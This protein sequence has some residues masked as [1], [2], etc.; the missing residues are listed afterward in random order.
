MRLF[1]ALLILVGS[2]AGVIWAGQFGVG[3]AVV[4]N[5]WEYKIPLL[6]GAPWRESLSEPGLTWRIPLV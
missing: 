2:L 4:V 6:L 3:P 5:E 1:F